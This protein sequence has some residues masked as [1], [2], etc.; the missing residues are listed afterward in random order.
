MNSQ[1]KLNPW[2]LIAIVV[3][4]VPLGYGITTLLKGSGSEKAALSAPAAPAKQSAAVPVEASPVVAEEPVATPRPVEE[5]PVSATPVPQPAQPSQT[6]QSH[7]PSQATQ[8]P[9]PSQTTQPSQKPQSSQSSAHAVGS[10]A[11]WTGPMRNGKPHGTGIMRFKTAHAID[12]SRMAQAG[13]YISD[14]EYR[15]GELVYGTWHHKDGSVEEQ[16]DN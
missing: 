1:S 2:V 7:Q 12:A 11:E 14:A 10:Y 15:N 3:I 9:Q 13:D 6:T 5:E 8:S 16:I 4:F